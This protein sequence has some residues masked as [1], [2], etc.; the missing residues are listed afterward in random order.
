MQGVNLT[1]SGE[2]GF[3]VQRAGE[4]RLTQNR[5]AVRGPA[6]TYLY[7]T[8]KSLCELGRPATLRGN[9]RLPLPNQ[10]FLKHSSGSQLG[11]AGPAQG[12]KQG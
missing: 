4:R 9:S 7:L 3:G 10:P 6:S 8:V 1:G 5:A 12:L 2:E 11:P